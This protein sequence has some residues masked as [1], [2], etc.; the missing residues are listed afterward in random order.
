MK[1]LP[2]L[3]AALAALGLAGC[4]TTASD[5][6]AIE[7]ILSN[8][9]NVNGAQIEAA[10]ANA[11]PSLA[12][13]F[14]AV[15]AQATAL[16][17]V[18][19]GIQPLASSLASIAAVA[20]GATGIVQP[21][22]EIAAAFCTPYNRTR[23]SVSRVGSKRIVRLPPKVAPGTVVDRPFEYAGVKVYARGVVVDPSL[24]K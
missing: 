10:L 2:L 14:E 3:A 19:C 24:V 15:G 23:V 13:K 5:Q 6:A 22:N 12:A 18:A 17:T 9:L 1:T 16:V 4:K 8:P 7:A 20:Y 11:N 21:A